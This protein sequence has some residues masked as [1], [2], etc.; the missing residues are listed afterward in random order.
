M[1]APCFFCGG[2]AHPATG[3]Q[4]TATCIACARCTRDFWRWVKGF[5]NARMAR[6]RGPRTAMSFYEAAAHMKGSC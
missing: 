5:T 4:Y 6:K 2:P 3:C 1:T